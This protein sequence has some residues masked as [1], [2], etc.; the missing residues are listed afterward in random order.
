MRYRVLIVDDD[1]PLLTILN[2]VLSTDY[3]VQAAG[4]AQE[5]FAL[6]KEHTFD[7][8][9]SDQ[10]MPGQLGTDFLKSV[11][12]LYP[13]TLRFI[14]TGESTFDVA[15]AAINAGAISHFFSKPFE[16]AVLT[17]TLRSH[18]QQREL[19]REAARLIRTV[20]AQAIALAR[21]EQENPGLLKRTM[22]D[23]EST[24]TSE[25]DLPDDIN[26]FLQTIREQTE[27]ITRQ[28]QDLGSVGFD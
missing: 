14:I 2:R 11:R 22:E 17:T 12:A 18:L 6:L 7:V 8:V 25:Q 27:R 24:P 3:D 4:S 13:D 1:R 19:M 16:E 5:A 28:L 23:L 10:Q 26:D 21:I 9:I 15:V 20:K